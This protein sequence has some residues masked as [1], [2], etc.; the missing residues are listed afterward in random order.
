MSE[1][2]NFFDQF[3]WT[4]CHHI[5][6]TGSKWKVFTDK[7]QHPFNWLFFIYSR[8]SR[9]KSIIDSSFG[10]SFYGKSFLPWLFFPF[11]QI[12][13]NEKSVLRNVLQTFHLYFICLSTVKLLQFSQS[14]QIIPFNTFYQ[15]CL[16]YIDFR[17]LHVRSVVPKL[18]ILILRVTRR[19]ILLLHCVLDDLTISPQNHKM[20]WNTI[21]LWSTAPKN[22]SLLSKENLANNSSCQDSTL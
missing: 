21:L 20:I 7:Q 4:T 19:V 10:V 11:M 18:Q 8:I 1:N 15:K 22:L 3:S 9:W 12:S 17:K 14:F 6:G 2:L 13:V 5:S 16:I